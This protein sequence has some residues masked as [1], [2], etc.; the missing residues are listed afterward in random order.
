MHISKL[1]AVAA[2]AVSFASMTALAGPDW[3]EN[4]DAGSLID[5]A[6]PVVGT[7]SG[8]F[9]VSGSLSSGRD[10]PDLEDL[11]LVRIDN[12]T[13]FKFDLRSAPF[14]SVIYL[15][16]VVETQGYG[17]LANDDFSPDT[18]NGSF[19]LSFATDSTE[20]FVSTP[21]VYALGISVGGRYPV[22]DSGLIFNFASNTEVSGPDG[23]AGGGQ[24]LQGWTGSGSGGA[25]T[26]FVEGTTFVDVPAPGAW[27]A[28]VS[29]LSLATRRR[30]R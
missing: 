25:Y 18:Q 1:V 29:A 22:G 12:P 15:F 14:D 24:P 8:L 26:L 20:A 4:G 9:S 13:A 10:T 17:L 27:L 7:A 6:Q 11:Y 21:G 28:G 30:R 23:P 2:S 16:R 19:M 3:V 5:T